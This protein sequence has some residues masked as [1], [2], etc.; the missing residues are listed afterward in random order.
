MFPF[1]KSAC[2]VKYVVASLTIIIIVSFDI[3]ARIT[4]LWA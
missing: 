3:S 1:T 2:P 4:L